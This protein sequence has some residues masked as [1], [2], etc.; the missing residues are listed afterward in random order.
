[1]NP[2]RRASSNS[3]NAQQLRSA[4]TITS[5]SAATESRNVNLAVAPSSCVLSSA[6]RPNCAIAALRSAIPEPSSEHA[7]GGSFD[8]VILLDVAIER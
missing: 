2:F 3:K 4:A 5:S 6:A 1:M 8:M 7:I